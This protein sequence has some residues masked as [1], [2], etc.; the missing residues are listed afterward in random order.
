MIG[1]LRASTDG[2]RPAMRRLHATTIEDRLAGHAR[3]PI[4]DRMY[5][6]AVGQAG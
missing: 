4:E 5:R 3:T 6:G 1:S 2:R